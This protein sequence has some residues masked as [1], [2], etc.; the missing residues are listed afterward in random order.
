MS[1]QSDHLRSLAAWMVKHNCHDDDAKAVSSAADKIES[2]ERTIADLTTR[3][4]A[5][6]QDVGRLRMVMRY[7]AAGAGNLSPEM[8]E[9]EGVSEINDGKMRAISL[10]AFVKIARDSIGEKQ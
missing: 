8:M 2:Q 4:K 6:E 7:V 9:L 5:L 10:E 1:Q 3:Y